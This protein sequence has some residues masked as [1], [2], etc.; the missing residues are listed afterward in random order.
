MNRIITLFL[1]ILLIPVL[2]AR[3][4]EFK[5]ES[6]TDLVLSNGFTEVL[7]SPEITGNL[8]ADLG[9][10]RLYDSTGSE[11]PYIQYSEKPVLYK[12]LFKEYAVLQKVHHYD[13]TRLVIH[14]PSKSTITNISLVIKN[15]D[16]RK[17]LTLNGSDDQKVWYALKEH[18]YFQSFYNDDK[19]SEIRVLNFPKSNYEYYELLVYDYF[20][21]PINILKVG[22]YDTSV[23]TGKYSVVK[24]PSFSQIDTLKQSV[25]QIH[26]TNQQYIDKLQFEIEGP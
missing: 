14:N 24:A 19:T 25:I 16:V 23:E 5:W 22:Y 11:I 7:L 6:K 17:W 4:Q 3:S 12:Q 10:I 26:Y 8:R 18:Y 1:F 20:D 13:Y 15:A 9:D 2:T 21:Y